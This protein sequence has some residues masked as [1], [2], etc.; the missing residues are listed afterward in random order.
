MVARLLNIRPVDIGPCRE[1]SLATPGMVQRRI[2]DALGLGDHN[3]GSDKP[4]LSLPFPQIETWGFQRGGFYE[5]TSG[6]SA[7][8]ARRRSPR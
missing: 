5:N 7:S 3:H 2:D 4:A 6:Q 1:G 8:P